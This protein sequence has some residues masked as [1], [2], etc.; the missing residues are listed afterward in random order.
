ML[1]A[2]PFLPCL[3]LRK[4]YHPQP[5]P[6]CCSVFSS[7]SVP[8]KKSPCPKLLRPLKWG[9]SL[10]FYQDTF[11]SS[12]PIGPT[13]GTHLAAR[14]R[15]DTQ[16]CVV[17]QVIHVVSEKCQHSSSTR[18]PKVLGEKVLRLPEKSVASRKPGSG[19]SLYMLSLWLI[20]DGS[21]KPH[22]VMKGLGF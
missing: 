3:V 13:S 8:F 12:C 22:A 17:S 5:R 15:E 7:A 4:D 9:I 18:K 14:M 2:I 1:K 11:Q 10:L 6:L 21:P 20:L 19:L 16:N